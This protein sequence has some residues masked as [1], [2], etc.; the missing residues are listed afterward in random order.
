MPAQLS[1][2]A[3]EPAAKPILGGKESEDIDI[4]VGS[5]FFALGVFGKYPSRTLAADARQLLTHGTL[6]VSPSAEERRK[7][8]L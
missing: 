5:I 3:P 8:T 1:A 7:T 6:P 2:S 4:H